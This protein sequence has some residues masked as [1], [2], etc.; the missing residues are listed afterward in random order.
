MRPNRRI[1]IAM[2]KAIMIINSNWIDMDAPT[3]QQANDERKGAPN[4]LVPRL[5]YQEPRNRG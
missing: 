2:M 3:Q 1:R 4:P 5:S